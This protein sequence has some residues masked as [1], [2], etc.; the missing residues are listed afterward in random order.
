MVRAKTAVLTKVVRGGITDKVTFVQT[1][2]G[3]KGAD[4]LETN[5]V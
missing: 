5:P 3:G 4:H 1:F 2:V